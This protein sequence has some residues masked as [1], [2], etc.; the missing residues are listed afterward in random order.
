M[1]LLILYLF[2]ILII[3]PT[4]SEDDYEEPPA[5]INSALEDGQE[6]TGIQNTIPSDDLARV[7]GQNGIYDS[8]KSDS[9]SS[10]HRSESSSSFYFFKNDVYIKPLEYPK[11]AVSDRSDNLRKVYVE[12]ISN[13]QKNARLDIREYI[14]K[15]LCIIFPSS[16]GYVLTTPDEVSLY[17]SG[18]LEEIEMMEDDTNTIK[19]DGDDR[20]NIDECTFARCNIYEFN[21]L[22][23]IRPYARNA[24]VILCWN[25]SINNTC[26]LNNSNLSCFL[27]SDMQINNSWNSSERIRC[28]GNGIEIPINN[29]TL[30]LNKSNDFLDN[31]CVILR[32]RDII[33]HLK[34]DNDENNTTRIY[35]I[36]DL[37]AFDD[38]MIPPGSLFVYWYY[39]VPK[40]YGTFK[41]ETIT[42]TDIEGSKEFSQKDLVIENQPLF[43]VTPKVSESRVYANDIL[44]LEF[45][46]EYLGGGP[47]SSSGNISVIFDNDASY[48]FVDENGDPTE[49]NEILDFKKDVSVPVKKFIIYT[50]KGI[51]SLPGIWINKKHYT[52]VEDI[53]V[54]DYVSR[55]PSIVGGLIAGAIAF[56]IFILT[57]IIKDIILC[58]EKDK[59][60]RRDQILNTL[61]NWDPMIRLIIM[62]VLSI[63]FIFIFFVIM[64]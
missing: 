63:L 45:D 19:D 43:K 60:T 29:D 10:G 49:A 1:R 18:T 14:D 39:I 40:S 11:R 50:Q 42:F 7:S 54:D 55:Y 26:L 51:R 28:I 34:C 37:I 15:N 58:E 6:P 47:Q 53:T 16:H 22:T 2:L 56:I 46:I 64:H 61:H 21:N 41:T 24:D 9:F 3:I 17:K 25:E 59:K 35:N 8:G 52:S 23:K 27:E 4:N 33:T 20:I 13:N 12:I 31:N 32:Y 48:Y 5:R 44:E 36:N 38:V 57:L 62:S 30:F